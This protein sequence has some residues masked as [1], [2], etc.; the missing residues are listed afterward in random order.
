MANG[1]ALGVH[2]LMGQEL[3]QVAIF[4]AP[5]LFPM[6]TVQLSTIKGF[7]LLGDVHKGA[8]FLQYRDAPNQE[9]TLQGRTAEDIDVAVGGFV[10]DGQS[11]VMVVA[12][13]H[14][15]A[16]TFTYE[17]RAGKLTWDGKRLL[18]RAR[19]AGCPP[20]TGALRFPCPP[21]PTGAP[22]LGT[23]LCGLSGGVAAV[24]PTDPGTHGALR[25]LEEAL[26]DAGEALVPLNAG[27]NPRALRYPPHRAADVKPSVSGE[28]TA[29]GARAHS[30]TLFRV[31]FPIW[32]TVKMSPGR[33]M[34][35]ATTSEPASS[36]VAPGSHIFARS[37]SPLVF[38]CVP[39][40]SA[41]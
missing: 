4:L 21:G 10:V 40:R 18:P 23:L 24:S 32:A 8:S 26:I 7:I 28:T 1:T 25:A 37:P 12:D 27:L 19:F 38:P 29:D 39:C 9:I 16:H 41:P 17:P 31:F 13:A 14:G 22:R 11:L 5:D 2:S 35:P 20:P 33:G 36:V 15:T 3:R 6:Y 30:T 34:A